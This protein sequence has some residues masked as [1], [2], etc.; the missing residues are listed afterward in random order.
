M[1]GKGTLQVAMPIGFTYT[2]FAS[3]DVF[4]SGGARA[5]LMNKAA[6]LSLILDGDTDGDGLLDSE[7][8]RYK[9][10]YTLADTCL[11]DTSDAADD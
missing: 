5:V 8:A 6:S 9:G 2:V 10:D 1:R 3:L 4:T 11:F 7:E